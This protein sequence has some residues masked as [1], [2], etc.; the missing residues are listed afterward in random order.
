M[1]R[2]NQSE[3]ALVVSL[4]K[5]A[6]VTAT[7]FESHPGAR[8]A[9]MLGGVEAVLCHVVDIAGGRDARAAVE[10]ALRYV[11]TPADV[12]ARKAVNAARASSKGAQQ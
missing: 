8:V 11:P 2:L 9:A 3:V 1:N 5:S 10:A 12:E 4:I 7:Q 6:A